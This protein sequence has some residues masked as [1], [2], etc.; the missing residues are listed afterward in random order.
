MKKVV[1]VGKT[2]MHG[3][4]CVGGLVESTAEPVRLIPYGSSWNTQDTPFM[5]G[6]IWELELT[7][8]AG[9]TPPHVEDHYFTDHKKVG[10]VPNLRDWIL[11]KVV[12]WQG[13]TINLFD[14]ALQYRKGGTAYVPTTGNVSKYST[15]FWILPVNLVYITI[16]NRPKYQLSALNEIILPYVG[17]QPVIPTILS[18][19]LVRLSL[20]R[21]WTGPDAPVDE[22]KR[23]SLQLS[24]WY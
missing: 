18:G 6:D 14:G 10:V 7:S 5:L 17:C 4:I 1:I 8:Q 22:D 19:S 2:R 3:G 16:K 13:A 15:G 11:S 23:H 9:A 12:P 24:G 21:P 20:A